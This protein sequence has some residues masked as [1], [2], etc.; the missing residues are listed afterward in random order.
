MSLDNCS[1]RYPISC[2]PAVVHGPGQILDR[3]AASPSPCRRR[4][5]G[6]IRVSPASRICVVLQMGSRAI[7]AVATGQR[8]VSRDIHAAMRT[9]HHA[10]RLLSAPACR[11]G[12][13]QQAPDRNNDQGDGNQYDKRA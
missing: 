10:R 13:P 7:E 3:F 5:D 8:F 9:L 2:I 1:M 11:S 6:L 4:N 12:G